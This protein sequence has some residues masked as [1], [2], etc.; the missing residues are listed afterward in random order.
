MCE[1]LAS[2]KQHRQGENR[3]VFAR[4]KQITTRAVAAPSID[5]TNTVPQIRP[6]SGLNA[7]KNSVQYV[8]ATLKASL[9]NICANQSEPNSGPITS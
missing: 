8:N 3:L 6:V 9:V 2:W 5:Q 1:R 7:S 4:I